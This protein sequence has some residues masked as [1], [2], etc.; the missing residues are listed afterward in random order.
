[1][2]GSIESLTSKLKNLEAK[3]LILEN[4]S[5]MIYGFVDACKTIIQGG[6]RQKK[7][8]MDE[9]EKAIESNLKEDINDKKEKGYIDKFLDL[10]KPNDIY[11]NAFKDKVI[12]KELGNFIK[13]NVKKLNNQTIG[14]FF[15]NSVMQKITNVYYSK[16]KKFFDSKELAP[17]I[18]ECKFNDEI[19]LNKTGAS[20][21]KALFK[22]K[23]LDAWLAIFG[24][25]WKEKTKN[26]QNIEKFLSSN[27]KK[28]RE[29]LTKY[30]F[31]DDPREMDSEELKE[32][33]G[34]KSLYEFISNTIGEKN[35][36]VFPI[37]LLSGKN[38]IKQELRGQLVRIINKVRKSISEKNDNIDNKDIMLEVDT[39]K[40]K[41]LPDAAEALV[42]KLKDVCKESFDVKEATKIL[43]KKE[44]KDI[45]KQ[46]D[47]PEKYQEMKEMKERKQDN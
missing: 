17:K 14:K 1:M 28:I 2:N 9:I 43:E 24:P 42:N 19:K 8:T 38:A 27:L 33:F 39:I 46:S 15:N 18:K 25:A 6:T 32:I 40:E 26:K 22:E 10:F 16:Y 44:E 47:N 5:K 4:K 13:A 41:K 30:S 31:W 45:N 36:A 29:K 12:I 34:G 20:I 7:E 21:R 35:I 3:K 23:T 11:K 37:I